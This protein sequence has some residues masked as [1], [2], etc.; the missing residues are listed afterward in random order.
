MVRS[1]PY[2]NRIILISPN[3]DIMTRSTTALREMS[4]VSKKDQTPIARTMVQ[5]ESKHPMARYAAVAIVMILTAFISRSSASFV[6]KTFCVRSPCSFRIS[7]WRIFSSATGDISTTDGSS[8]PNNESL[9]EQSSA[10]DDTLSIDKREK[11]RR[12]GRNKNKN[13]FR[14]H[15]VSMLCQPNKNPLLLQYHGAS[16]RFCVYTVLVCFRKDASANSI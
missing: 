15:V 9:D 3:L 7:A 5:F 2:F 8:K 6:G 1:L 14:Q 12:G 4:S 13:R 16:R 10:A 11:I